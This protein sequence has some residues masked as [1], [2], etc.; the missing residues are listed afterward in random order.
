MQNFHSCIIVD[1]TK[2]CALEE[3]RSLGVCDNGENVTGFI[4]W[5]RI[6]VDRRGVFRK[7]R[8]AG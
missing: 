6:V 8:N 4:S 3:A 2:Y 1:L 7:I 5:D